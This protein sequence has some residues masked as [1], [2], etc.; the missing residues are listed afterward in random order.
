M[1][2][3]EIAVYTTCAPSSGIPA[4]DYPGTVAEIARW[5]E[6][7][8]CTGILVYTDH[9][10][11]DPWLVAQTIIGATRSHLPTRRR[12][13]GLHASVHRREDGDVARRTSTSGRLHL[14]FVAGGF[15]K[16][17][18]AFE[19]ALAHD[20]P[21]RASRGVRVD[22]AG[23]PRQPARVTF[24]G[25][26][27]AVR[28]LKLTP[29]L[30]GR[31]AAGAYGVRVVRRRTRGRAHARGD[32][33]ALSG[34]GGRGRRSRRGTDADGD[35]DRHHR[36]RRTART[37]GVWPASA[38]R[39]PQGS[40]HPRARA[41]GT[42]DSEWHR[43]L[44]PPRARRARR[45]P[46]LAAPVPNYQTFCPYLVGSY[47]RVAEEVRRY[48]DDGR[49]DGDSRRSTRRL[50]SSSTSTR[51]SP[52]PRAPRS[53]VTQR[54]DRD[55]ARATPRGRRRRE[56]RH[57]CEQWRLS[58]CRTTSTRSRTTAGAIASRSSE[59]PSRSRS[60]RSRAR[61]SR[62]SCSTP[63]ASAATGSACCCRSRRIAV[64]AMHA[65]LKADCCVR[66]ARHR[67][68]AA[69]AARDD[70][71]ARAARARADDASSSPPL[72][73]AAAP[74]VAVGSLGRAF[75]GDRSP[76]ELRARRRR[77]R[78]R[79][80]RIRL[81]TPHRRSEPHP[82]HVGLDG[83]AEGRGRDAPKRDPLRRVGSRVLRARPTTTGCP[84][85]R[86]S[87]STSRRSTS[88]AR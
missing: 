39:R 62:D 29:P 68:P 41:S 69:R 72:V 64:V 16:D 59:E 20:R 32:G 48:L 80:E 14:N 11:V 87:T 36:P 56:R 15:R 54:P 34:A 61:G 30:E 19:D 76:H 38:S 47:E 43:Q 82:V 55:A 49:V 79:R 31:A 71:R 22:R 45:R 83:R 86:R 65:A 1:R 85:I 78:I 8:G 7:A 53:P 21:L 23:A 37:P 58:C 50:T 6:D 40:D 24:S 13:A 46:L 33:R 84:G 74:G 63:A 4:G 73:D 3:A 52:S 42:S 25:R 88:T 28:D 2:P 9:G 26:Y 60:S 12:A 70:R 27:Y 17:L 5:S 75:A 57:G 66:A 35:Q 81:A 10:L 51:C 77:Q 18:L 67:E 44:R